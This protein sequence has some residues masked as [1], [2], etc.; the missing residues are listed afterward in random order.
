MYLAQ[1]Y[2]IVLFEALEKLGDECL[3]DDIALRVETTHTQRERERE[4][5][6]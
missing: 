1:T 2:C 6:G 4:G 5:G 3:T